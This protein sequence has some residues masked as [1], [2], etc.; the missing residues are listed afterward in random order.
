[1]LKNYFDEPNK[2]FNVNRIVFVKFILAV[3]KQKINFEY[4]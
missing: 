3:V 2:V 1:M 4:Y